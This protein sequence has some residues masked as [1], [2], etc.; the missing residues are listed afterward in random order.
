MP[1]QLYL[2]CFNHSVVAGG[3]DDHVGES[4]RPPVPTARPRLVGDPAPSLDRRSQGL[5][6]ILVFTQ[7]PPLLLLLKG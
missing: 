5:F 2:A 4:K 7:A 1:L 3:A 6:A